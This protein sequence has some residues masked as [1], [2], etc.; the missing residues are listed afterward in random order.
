MHADR[1]FPFVRSV[2]HVE[3]TESTNGLA[4]SLIAEGPLDLPML[5][6]ADRQTRGRGQGSNRWWSDSGSL[7][8]TV[9]LDPR[10]IGLTLAQESRIS[11]TVAA[12]VVGAIRARYQG[13]RPGIRWPNDIEV[14]GRKLG[15]ILPERAESPHGPRLLVGIGLNVRTRLEDAPEEIRRMAGTL[16]G[17][18][19][20]VPSSD[21]IAALLV[22]I[23]GRFRY[24]LAALADDRADQPRVWN[25]LDTLVGS[26]VRIEAGS[27]WIEAIAAG[28]DDS[29]GLRLLQNGRIRV[30]HAGRVLRD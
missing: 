30:I 2:L 13:C 1:D 12:S 16:S 9:I 5:V 29:G 15:G 4:R 14:G 27:E 7:T 24:P 25:Q 8:A 17:W 3:E 21:P 26:T 11:L 20:I 22:G 6:R 10:S 23:L 28:I 18:A 19:E